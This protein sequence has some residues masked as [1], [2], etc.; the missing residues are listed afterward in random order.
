MFVCVIYVP[1]HVSNIFES[2]R[3]MLTFLW[4]NFKPHNKTV[5]I[6]NLNGAIELAK[7]RLSEAQTQQNY[8]IKRV[9]SAED[10]KSGD[11]R[12]FKERGERDFL[13]LID[14]IQLCND[15]ELTDTSKKSLKEFRAK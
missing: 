10:L 2:I 13:I 11:L 8:H 4:K 9:D 1:F 14:A 5:I 12:P 3:Q 6:A 7:H 15:K